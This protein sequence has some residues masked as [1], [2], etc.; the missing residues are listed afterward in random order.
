MKP[1]ADGPQ[2][3]KCGTRGSGEGMTISQKHEETE[4]VVMN[5]DQIHTLPRTDEYTCPECGS[6]DA[7]YRYQ[8]TRAA[9]EPTTIILKCVDCGEKWRKY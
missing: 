8:Q 5:E 4:I 1:S 2:C 6:R 7:Y 3:K 9:D